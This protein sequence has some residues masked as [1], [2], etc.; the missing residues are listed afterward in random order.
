MKTFCDA[1]R[2]KSSNSNETWCCSS[3]QIQMFSFFQKFEGKT[4]PVKCDIRITCTVTESLIKKFNF[5]RS[6]Y[7]GMISIIS[8][9][10]YHIKIYYVA[11]TSFPSKSYLSIEQKRRFML[12]FQWNVKCRLLSQFVGKQIVLSAFEVCGLET[13][14]S[15]VFYRQIIPS[16]TIFKIESKNTKCRRNEVRSKERHMGSLPLCH[17]PVRIV[18]IV[19]NQ[20]N[21]I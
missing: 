18:Y 2:K 8:R 15:E 17:F 11:W 9:S 10:I 19:Y 14:S 13:R 3:K 4:N 7:F 12:I 6:K 21:W 16:W 1:N 5:S 20:W